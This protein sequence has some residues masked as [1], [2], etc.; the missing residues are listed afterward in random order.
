M[1][2]LILVH[3]SPVLAFA[4]ETLDTRAI[5]KGYNALK[6]WSHMPMVARGLARTR[7]MM[8]Q[9]GIFTENEVQ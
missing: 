9:A 2:M 3:N 7:T 1:S 8:I 4:P 6:L 5:I